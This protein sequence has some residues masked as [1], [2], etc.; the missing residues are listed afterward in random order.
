MLMLKYQILRLIFTILLIFIFSY[1]CAL[2]SESVDS[3]E[4]DKLT[5]VDQV[6]SAVRKLS[7]IVETAEKENRLSFDLQKAVL[8]KS[9]ECISKLASLKNG[10]NSNQEKL[11]VFSMN[12]NT[13]KYVLGKNEK[14]IH[15]LQE[16]ILDDLK[17]PSDYF[18]S[19][20]WQNPQYLISLSSYWLGWNGYY[21]CLQMAEDDKTQTVWLE[22][23][24]KGFSRAFIDF[25]E[26]DVILRS[27]LGRALCHSRLKAYGNAKKDLDA[28]KRRLNKD[29]PLY[30]R[31][32]YEENRILYISGN[33]EI[34]LRNIDEIYEDYDIDEIPPEL[35]AGFEQLKAKILVGLVEKPV[36]ADNQSEKTAS[37]K[38]DRIFSD[39]KKLA[40][41]ASG[42]NEFY[43]YCRENVEQLKDMSFSEIG[44]VGALGI[45]DVYFENKNYDA[46]LSYYLPVFSEAPEILETK[47]DI[48]RFRIGYIYC[49]NEHWSEAI[50]YL[51]DFYKKHQ[52]SYLMEHAIPLYYTAAANNYKLNSNRDA[53][54][55]FINAAEVYATKCRGK[56]P[57]LSDVH[58]QLGQ[59]YEKLG[60]TQKAVK[61]FLHV[62]AES[63][64][65][66]I[67]KYY[68]LK[69][70]V[71]RLE[72]LKNTGQIPSSESDRIVRDSILAIKR[73]NDIALKTGQPETLK[74][75]HPH[76]VMLQAE[77]LTFDIKNRCEEVLVQI[78]DFEKRF[79]KD[80][81]LFPKVFQLRA[82]CYANLGEN[83]QLKSEIDRFASPGNISKTS[84]D[85]VKDLAN[86]FYYYAQDSRKKH[87]MGES[88]KHSQGAL[89]IYERLYDL[90]CDYPD[91]KKNCD[92]IQLRMA[93]IYI[94]NNQ[95]DAAEAL[96]REIL[97]RNSLSADAYYSLGL[98]YEKRGQWEDALATWRRFSDGV[99]EGTYHWFESRYK[100][101]LAHEKLG[102]TKRACDILTITMVLHPD[103]GSDELTRKYQTL[104]NEICKEMPE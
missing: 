7:T 76:M 66:A 11:F 20:E 50:S 16:N 63:T 8:T 23:S 14:I 60:K 24:I 13:I 83:D 47:M 6:G 58:F 22:E 25:E 12:R 65:G 90:S 42:I 46:A 98:L 45:G 10:R 59:Y 100:T 78:N 49:L 19:S 70:Y 44:P 61:E 3:V 34:A 4:I 89:M 21:G 85:A 75:I 33:L 43:R 84:Y 56:C 26:E 39:L 18:K 36:I 52:D 73:Y 32:L 48:V 2:A 99:K 88:R 92:A 37:T 102:N 77:L 9:G 64:N 17:D 15:F 35:S 40:E 62:D 67:A 71:E 101:A 93:Q 94:E 80:K 5:T 96:Y 104:K 38:K 1:V 68:L 86:Y 27:L 30:L 28:V 72:D 55:Q 41:K 57:D 103:L 29:H 87:Q 74:R 69:H 31:C 53:Y 54:Q 79:P 81:Q 95:L 82:T 97:K 51:K 91:F